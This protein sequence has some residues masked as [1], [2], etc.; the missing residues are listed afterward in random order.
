[1]SC[2]LPI[3]TSQ[4]LR[5]VCFARNHAPIPI[6]RRQS[7]SRWH[8]PGKAVHSTFEQRQQRRCV[9]SYSQFS[10]ILTATQATVPILL[11]TT[12]AA[13][14]DEDPTVDAAFAAAAQSTGAT[15][16]LV[17]VLAALVFGLLVVVTGGVGTKVMSF[18]SI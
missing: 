12:L 7:R 5:S 3:T 2:L 6:T 10:Q 11:A 8:T 14:A 16:L 18:I 17:S 15:D 1:M 9:C 13:V 4:S